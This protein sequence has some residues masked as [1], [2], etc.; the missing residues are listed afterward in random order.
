MAHIDE[1]ILSDMIRPLLADPENI[2]TP[3]V[4]QRHVATNPSHAFDRVLENHRQGYPSKQDTISGIFLSEQDA[5]TAGKAMLESESI[6]RQILVWLNYKN[7]S[8][9]EDF[10]LPISDIPRLEGRLPS[11]AIRSANSPVEACDC[12]TVRMRL[13][14]DYD[15][16]SGRGFLKVVTL[17]PTPYDEDGNPTFAPLNAA[18]LMLGSPVFQE[19]PLMEMVDLQLRAMPRAQDID[20]ALDKQGAL[21]VKYPPDDDGVSRMLRLGD[22]RVT[23]A[24]IDAKG[25]ETMFSGRSL[26]ETIAEDEAAAAVKKTMPKQLLAASVHAKASK[27]PSLRAE[28]AKIA[29][30]MADTLSG[31]DMLERSAQPQP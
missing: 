15:A 3:H 9:P 18:R 8:Q 6:R 4:R 26:E 1:T 7:A 14:F 23:F 16:N 19:L 10:H 24:W 27:N 20:H 22:D 2:V 12:K 11:A 17:H 21:C 13:A 5:R 25:S 30:I 31:G 29:H 28:R